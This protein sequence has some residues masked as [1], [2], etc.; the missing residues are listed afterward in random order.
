MEVVLDHHIEV[1]P[2][3]RGG[4]PRI[5]GT[6][7]TIADVVIMHLRMGQSLEE[8]AGRYDLGLADLYAAMAYYYDHRE[9]IDRSIAADEAF[10]EAFRR[11]S[12]SS[13]QARLRA[14]QSA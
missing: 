8:I 11:S 6:R 4:R 3:V 12:P 9:E 2:G 14:L 7:F 10:A 1:T 13:L 5:I